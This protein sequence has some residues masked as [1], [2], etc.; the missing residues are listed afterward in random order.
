ML[1]QFS[2]YRASPL[3]LY[4]GMILAVF[5]EAGGSAAIALSLRKDARLP[6]P[7]W[8]MNLSNCGGSRLFPRLLVAL[9]LCFSTSCSSYA[10]INSCVGFSNAQYVSAVTLSSQNCC[11]LYSA[12]QCSGI[13]KSSPFFYLSIFQNFLGFD[14][15]R[16]GISNCNY[17]RCLLHYRLYSQ[18]AAQVS[19]CRLP[20]LRLICLYLYLAS[21]HDVSNHGA[22]C[23]AQRFGFFCIFETN[24]FTTPASSAS[25]IRNSS[26][27]VVLSS[28]LCTYCSVIASNAYVKVGVLLCI[29]H[30]VMLSTYSLVLSFPIH[31]YLTVSTAGR[32]GIS[33]VTGRSGQHVLDSGTCYYGVGC[34]GGRVVVMGGV[35]SC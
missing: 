22:S 27:L 4:N 12:N 17:A 26:I 30:L 8:P 24:V 1:L 9:Y 35:V 2:G 15:I 31:S 19:E 10:V 25:R 29:F 7:A 11:L 13:P 6:I 28:L 34:G 14:F 23:L 16:S 33:L 3:P 5:H 21:L 18:Y 32:R 20:F